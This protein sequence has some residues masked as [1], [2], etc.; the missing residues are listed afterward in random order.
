MENALFADPALDWAT[1]CAIV[2][3][4]GYAG[5]YA[6][7]YPLAD[8]DWP[9]LRSLADEPIRCGLSLGGIY[10]N[11]DLAL[12][13]DAPAS[14]RL[15]RL[16]AEVDPAPRIELSVKWSDPAPLP[17][18]WEDRLVGRLVP[19]AEIA[20]RRGIR[21]TLYPHSFYPLETAA[22]AQRLTARLGGDA[23]GYTFA[24]SHAFALHSGHETVALL[25]RHASRIDSFNICGC[26][27]SAPQPPARCRHLPLDEGDLA[28]APLLQALVSRGY[29][30]E[31][32][33]QGHGWTGD[34][35]AMLRR[36]VAAY[37]RTVRALLPPC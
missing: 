27:R 35:P 6:V 1:R 18:N 31:V 8:D 9:R 37:D 12:P 15:A 22:Q 10:A 17:E 23:V 33:V 34:L 3:D 36:C 24:T 29:R 16:F 20:R 26:H 14:R 4:A 30:G 28:L 2:A 11:L 32:I 13:A 25:E 5:I 21:V 7:P 19:L